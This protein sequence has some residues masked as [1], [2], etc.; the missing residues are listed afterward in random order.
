YDSIRY[1]FSYAKAGKGLAEPFKRAQKDYLAV[2]LKLLMEAPNCDE[3]AKLAK[4]REYAEKLVSNKGP[5]VDTMRN[6]FGDETMRRVVLQ[7]M[8]GVAG[9]QEEQEE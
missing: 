4:N 3:E 5:A 2:Y 1:Q 9:G 7:H 6:H 8:Y